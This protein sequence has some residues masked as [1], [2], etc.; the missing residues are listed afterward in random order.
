MTIYGRSRTG[1]IQKRCSDKPKYSL[2]RHTPLV[3]G[4]VSGGQKPCNVTLNSHSP[5][6]PRIS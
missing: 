3:G 6:D 1:V 5:F 2:K 4:G